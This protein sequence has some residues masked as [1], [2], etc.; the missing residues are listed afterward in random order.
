MTTNFQ[1]FSNSRVGV[2]VV[3]AGGSILAGI[4]SAFVDVVLKKSSH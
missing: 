2:D 3:V 4:R 1:H